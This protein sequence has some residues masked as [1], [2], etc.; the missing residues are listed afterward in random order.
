MSQKRWTNH[1]ADNLEPGSLRLM[2]PNMAV[3]EATAATLGNK[4]L[5][6]AIRGMRIQTMRA[7]QGPR[8]PFVEAASKLM[9]ELIRTRKSFPNTFSNKQVAAVRRGLLATAGAD[10]TSDFG[11]AEQIYY[12]FETL[13][14]ALDQIEACGS[15][16]DQLFDSI[17]NADTYSPGKFAR[18][19]KKLAARF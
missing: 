12:S 9:S 8:G 14:L 16:L 5:R 3:I 7:A 10:R 11:E 13:C 18:L 2:L 4:E 6:S 17:A 15:A 1:R 19:T